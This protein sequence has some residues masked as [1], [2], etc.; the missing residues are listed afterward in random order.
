[1]RA[2]YSIC[3]RECEHFTL[4]WRLTIM[5][6]KRVS[7]DEQMQLIM[8]CRQS[9]LSDY[10]W[11]QMHD[12]NPG[13]FYNWISR[14]KKQGITLPEPSDLGK[15]TAS[16]VQEV[17]KL[18]LI[19]EEKNVLANTFATDNRYPT[20]NDVAFEIVIHNATI[21]VFNNTDSRMLENLFHCL[22]GVMNAG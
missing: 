6:S 22:G 18:E 19:P 17:V 2:F 20:A 4:F 11:C 9:G 5:K 14:M 13:T 12:I 8:E 10:Q 15:R 16:A 21:R 1:M 7:C 3:L